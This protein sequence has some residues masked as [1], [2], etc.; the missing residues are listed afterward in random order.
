MKK[1]T[2]LRARLTRMF[3]IIAVL[4]LLLLTGVVYSLLTTSINIGV[5]RDLEEVLKAALAVANYTHQEK[6]DNVYFK[7]VD[8]TFHPLLQNNKVWTDAIIE[9]LLNKSDFDG[10][11]L[12]DKTGRPLIYRFKENFQDVFPLTDSL[13]VKACLPTKSDLKQRVGPNQNILKTG[14]VIE[15][16]LGRVQGMLVGSNLLDL[17]YIT[18]LNIV[19]R[20]AGFYEEVEL[21]RRDYRL[22]MFLAFLIIAAAM[23]TLTAG[24]AG[25]F[26]R[27]FVNPIGK[28][29]EATHE[30][31]QGNIG[32]QLAELPQ[33][34]IGDL[35]ASFNKMSRD[36]A[37][38]RR[39][40]IQAERIAA[41]Q[42]IARRLAHE[43]KN[44]LTPIQLSIQ[45]LRD[46]YKKDSP[47][48]AQTFDECTDTI[49][50][51]VEA[52]RRLVQEFS[53]FARMPAP[54]FQKTNIPA[55]LTEL[56]S[57]NTT[58]RPTIR[59]ILQINGETPL[60]EADGEQLR[61]VFT[62]LIE[63]AVDAMTGQTVRQLS[64]IVTPIND[65][66]EIA[67]S[68]TGQGILPTHLAQVFQPYFTTKQNGTGLGLAIAERIIRDH[69]GQVKVESQPGRGATFRITLPVYQPEPAEAALRL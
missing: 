46:E 9:E 63:N 51:E 21:M 50:Q 32:F 55:I 17:E 24:I 52:L 49:R 8:L 36:L 44:P 47:N 29:A 15:D 61:R 4:P 58:A 14:H 41:W 40:L 34:E 28:L 23:A 35:M 38:H 60:I 54:S 42:G 66:L 26:A 3:G 16:E 11:E 18:N 19:E 64:I 1:Q 25:F 6:V 10:L 67:V 39:L 31:A 57:F 43:I 45:H 27:K 48:F 30:L 68:D 5:N 69:Q 65:M 22:A 13:I 20:N 59:F 56:V 7:L 12:Y 37:E 62:N 53:E 33:D 2:S